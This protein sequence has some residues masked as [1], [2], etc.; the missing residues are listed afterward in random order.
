MRLLLLAF[1][2]E[3]TVGYIHQNR[4]LKRYAKNISL[5]VFRDG[6]NG[7]TGA[8][9]QERARGVTAA[10]TGRRVVCFLVLSTKLVFTERTARS[11]SRCVLMNFS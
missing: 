10:S 9:R 7:E 2:I 3:R 4:R 5:Y 8:T 1:V 11:W 6:L